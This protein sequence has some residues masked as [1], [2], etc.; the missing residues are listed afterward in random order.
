M[1][2]VVVDGISDK[3]TRIRL[4]LFHGWERGSL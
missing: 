1:P 2:I 4:A 3:E